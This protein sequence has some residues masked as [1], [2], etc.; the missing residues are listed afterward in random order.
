MSW[1][2]D[3][4]LIFS[5][6]EIVEEDIELEISPV[7]QQINDWLWE[8]GKGELDNLSQHLESSRKSMQSCVYGGAFNYLD[9]VQFKEL[10]NAQ[11]WC[12]RDSV[13]LLIQ[14]EQEQQFT[15]YAFVD[16]TLQKVL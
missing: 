13:Q 16:K 3:V 4:I 6:E 12:V 11:S 5:L 10:V 15:V 1:V 7:L 8:N 9:L 14:E 2:T